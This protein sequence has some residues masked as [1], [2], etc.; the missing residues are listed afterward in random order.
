MNYEYDDRMRPGN[1]QPT[2]LCATADTHKIKDLNNITLLKIK[3]RPII[4]QTSFYT[5]K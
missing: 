1:S 2:Q 4:D 3:F 5:Y